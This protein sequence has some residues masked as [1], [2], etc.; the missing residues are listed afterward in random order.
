[1]T[2]NPDEHI[3]QKRKMEVSS[4]SRDQIIKEVA[5][6]KK[7]GALDGATDIFT[8][9]KSLEK[10][11]SK[12]LSAAQRKSFQRSE[13]FE[14]IERMYYLD[15]ILNRSPDLRTISDVVD[16][17]YSIYMDKTQKTQV[18]TQTEI[19]ATDPVELGADLMIRKFENAHGFGPSDGSWS[20]VVKTTLMFIIYRD[21][22]ATPWGEMFY[23]DL[24]QFEEVVGLGPKP[25]LFIG[26]VHSTAF[27]G[28]ARHKLTN[29][30]KEE[31]YKL[32][33]PTMKT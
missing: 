3:R 1:M 26:R 33:D 13:E 28:E 22:K 4:S 24:W 25:W 27:G 14:S 11:E 10:T 21:P 19:E 6:L 23:T 16:K 7:S 32:M 5:E 2:E 20:M 31:A 30:T 8:L 18:K 9:S 15:S 17:C 12:H 29:L